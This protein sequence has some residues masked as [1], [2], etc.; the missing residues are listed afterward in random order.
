ML[1]QF[2]LLP[3]SRSHFLG[4]HHWSTTGTKVLLSTIT[5]QK[6]N[7]EVSTKMVRS[8]QAQLSKKGASPLRRGPLK[9]QRYYM[10]KKMK[11]KQSPPSDQQLLEQ[12]WG[13]HWDA[14]SGGSKQTTT[15]ALRV[16]VRT[17]S[18]AVWAG[19]ILFVCVLLILAGSLGVL[20]FKL[21][22]EAEASLA[23]TQFR[24]ICDRALIQAKEGL[25][26][27]RW[28]GVTLASFV[29]DLYPHA[30]QWPFVEWLGFEH[31][32][33]N[34]LETSRGKDMGFVPFVKPSILPEFEEFAQHVY[35][36]LEFPN[37][38]G[39]SDEGFGVWARNKTVEPV[40]TYH[41][42]TA[43]TPYGSPYEILAPIFRTDEGA[44][45]VL[46][47]NVHSQKFT[48]QAI[49]K[50][51]TCSNNRKEEYKAQI[52]RETA[53][54]NSTETLPTMPPH[55]CGVITDIFY[56]VKLGGRWSVANFLPIYPRHDPLT[57]SCP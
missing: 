45:K 39:V 14:N 10:S 30:N 15:K 8:N 22:T 16:R 53:E 55:Q 5:S 48:G 43:E 51:L 21:L 31:V 33:N 25:L 17:I 1:H 54:A 2:V 9:K 32:V 47:F 56:N 27:R 18:Q 37:S 46:L 34:M 50:L 57:V 12:H 42:T 52:E 35:Q 36:K 41:D 4:A 24:S 49:D 7:A 19:R 20:A 44:H 38:T 26:S 40:Q 6:P 28:A 11:G 3:P 23:E 13:K 29:S